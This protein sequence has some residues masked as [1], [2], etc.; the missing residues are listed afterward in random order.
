M[1]TQLLVL[2]LSH[3]EW[4]ID[5]EAVANHG[6]AG[7]IY[8]CTEGVDYKDPTY[9]DAKAQAIDNGLMWGSYH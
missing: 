3:H 6:I 2:D 8:K 1:S 4:P 5:F 9:S 7:I